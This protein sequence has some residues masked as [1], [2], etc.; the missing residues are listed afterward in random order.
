MKDDDSAERFV[1][2]FCGEDTDSA[3]DY[4]RMD[5]SWPT[6]RASQSLGAHGA[7]LRAAIQPGM[8]LGDGAEADENWF[9]PYEGAMN[10]AA[11]RIRPAR[12]RLTDDQAAQ[13]VIDEFSSRGID[14]PAPTATSI[15]RNL[16]HPFWPFLHPFRA[17][18]EGWTWRWR[19]DWD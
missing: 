18:R 1:C 7:C 11:H 16:L 9:V 17:R 4:V 12:R 6:S 14:L 15:A 8:P 10:A 3:Q 2:A 13:I 5:L 19:P